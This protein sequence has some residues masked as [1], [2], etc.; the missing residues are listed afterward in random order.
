MRLHK[1]ETFIFQIAEKKFKAMNAIDI[2]SIRLA[3]FEI[4][5]AFLLELN[6][7]SSQL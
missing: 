5:V 2:L 6:L 7:I 4:N 3:S 1:V